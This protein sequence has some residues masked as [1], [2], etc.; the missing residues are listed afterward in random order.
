MA[1]NFVQPGGTVTL[2][3]PYAVASGGLVKVGAMVGVALADAA[4]N[5]PVETRREGVF[6]VAKAAGEAWVQGAKLYHD[7]ANKRLTTTAAGNTLVGA[8]M[9]AQAAGDV[10]GRAI[11]TGQIA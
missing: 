9:Q 2:I 8:A 11:L 7:D 4:Q 6:D 5:A 3:A 1:R 10:I